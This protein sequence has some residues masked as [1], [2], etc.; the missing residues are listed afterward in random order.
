MGFI[1]IRDFIVMALNSEDVFPKNNAI[2]FQVFEQIFRVKNKIAGHKKFI[3]LCVFGNVE[4][5]KFQ[6]EDV[7]EE[8]VK[9]GV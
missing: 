5:V 2:D 3:S 4:N 7:G 1:V 8:E 6:A 9:L